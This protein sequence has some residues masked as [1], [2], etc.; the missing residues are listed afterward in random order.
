M[1]ILISS[2]GRRCEIVRWF[3]EELQKNNGKL[4]ACDID[5]TAPALYE[6][7]KHFIIDKDNEFDDI[8]KICKE[9]DIK[10]VMTLIDTQLALFTGYQEMF[11]RN[12][13][14]LIQSDRN[15]IQNTYDKM[16]CYTEYKDILSLGKCY[17]TADNLN[18]YY[19]KQRK[20]SA[21]QGV[22]KTSIK[23]FI[24]YNEFAQPAYKGQEY[25]VSAYFDL[26]EGKLKDIFM[27]KKLMMR[28]GETERALPYWDYM[29]YNEIKK[30]EN[31][32]GFKGNIDIDLIIENDIIYIIDINTRFGGGYP[33]AH[34]SGKNYF[35]H[36]I[37]DLNNM[38]YECELNNYTKDITICKVQSYCVIGER[39]C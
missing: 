26:K 29:I 9:N 3:R 33:F 8:I 2:V 12:G 37:N 16:L 20:G 19:I 1:N 34:L 24:K 23:M 35:K 25:N 39:K 17:Q 15:V 28:A 32:K 38:Y 7:H 11:E 21:S 18:E 31:I 10:Y 14:T 22:R 13:I 30:L 6:A 4:F 36:I 5:K 27:C